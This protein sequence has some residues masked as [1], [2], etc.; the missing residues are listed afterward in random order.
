MLVD[1]PIKHSQICQIL[2]DGKETNKLQTGVYECYHFNFDQEI[3]PLQDFDK[4]FPK[5]GNFGCYGVCDSPEQLLKL[6][7][8]NV[9]TGPTKYVISVTPVR[10][11]PSEGWRWHKW[12]EY[13][14]TQNP[15]CEYLYDE[16]N[17][18]L[19]YYYH[20]YEV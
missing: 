1:V 12:G 18:D 7:P 6:L 11:D 15:E 9:L 4:I 16:P 20:I 17:I 19:V 14:G 8:E 5:L 13:I 10:K 3:M 2:S